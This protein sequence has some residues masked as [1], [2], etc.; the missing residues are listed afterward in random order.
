MVLHDVS[1]QPLSSSLHLTGVTSSDNVGGITTTHSLSDGIEHEV[2]YTLFEEFQSSS[3][4]WFTMHNDRYATLAT[5]RSI[6]NSHCIP[7]SHLC[8]MGI[9]GALSAL[10]LICGMSVFPLDPVCLH[11]L[12]HGCNLHSIHPGFLGKWHLWLKLVISD[13]IAL[14]PNGSA[15]DFWAC[16]ANY[17]DIQASLCTCGYTANLHFLVGHLFVWS[18]EASHNAWAVM[19]LHRTIVGTEPATHP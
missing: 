2:I 11:Y 4:E 18:C 7:S 5:T 3:A 16:F 6:S 17:F 1:S 8:S 10:S 15:A 14:G 13:W 9:L 12:V 19:I